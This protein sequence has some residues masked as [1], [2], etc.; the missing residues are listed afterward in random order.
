MTEGYTIVLL[1][2][3]CLVY[4]KLCGARN[5]LKRI[6]DFCEWSEKRIKGESA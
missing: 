1:L 3:L 2:L 6:A 5:Q 4:G